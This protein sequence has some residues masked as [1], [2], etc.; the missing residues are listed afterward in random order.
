[1]PCSTD[2]IRLI[3]T[4]VP[5]QIPIAILGLFMFG[6]PWNLPHIASI[7]VGLLAGVVFIRAKQLDRAK[8]LVAGAD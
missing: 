4:I 8:Q 5:A 2:R 3:S 6:S 1:M 7:L